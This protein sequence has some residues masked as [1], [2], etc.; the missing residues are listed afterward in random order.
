MGLVSGLDVYLSLQWERAAH[1]S[2]LYYLGHT[3]SLRQFAKHIDN[4]RRGDLK[5]LEG[6]MEELHGPASA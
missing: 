2:E 1:D 3:F 4:R 5:T 6:R